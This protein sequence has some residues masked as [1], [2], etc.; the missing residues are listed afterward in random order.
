M[1]FDEHIT[2]ETDLASPLTR[3]LILA[4]LSV[5]FLGLASM[6]ARAET[7]LAAVAAN[8]TGTAEALLPLFREA[9]G[10][11]LTLTTGSTGKLHAQIGQGAPFDLMLSAD[12]GTPARLL[13]AGK[14]VEG[15]AFTYAMG[16]LTLWS[17]EP[18]RIGP[19]GHAALTDPDLRFVAIANPDLAPF[20]RAAREALQSLGL[21][22][23]LQPK[24]VMGQN[25]GQTHSM[26]ASGA[27]EV[28]FVTLSA[29]LAQPD[30]DRGSRWDVPPDLFEPIRQDAVLLKAGAENDAARAFLDFLRTPQ[31]AA[32]IARFGYGRGS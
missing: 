5:L 18:D 10:H 3:R 12:A 20:G 9:T 22:D 27:A 21:W 24:I 23:S 14:A 31:A 1:C 28:G 4:A 7:A 17:A 29:V 11:D 25:V 19:D 2:K 32:V 26:I 6:A 15:S 8:F 16:R 13:A 30:G